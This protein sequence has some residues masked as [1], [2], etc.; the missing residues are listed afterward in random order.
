MQLIRKI[1]AQIGMDKAIAYSS[2]ARVIQGFTGIATIFFI[3]FFL[4]DV[5]QGFYFTFGSI[6]ALQIFFELGLTSI[7]TQYVAHEAA[8]LELK[9]NRFYQGEEKYKSRLASLIRFCLRWYA[10]LAVI[11]LLFLYVIGI[12]YFNKYSGNQ[13]ETVNWEWPWILICIGTSI[14]FFE[15]PLTSILTGLG[16]I[17]EMNK[18][19]FWQQLIIPTSTW[20][21][22][23]CG[24]KLYVI[25]IGYLLSTIVWFVYVFH[26]KLHVI[27]FNLLKEKISDRVEYLKEI[28]PYQWRIALSWISGYFVFQFFTP[29]L[30]ATEGAVVAGQ[31]G[32]TLQALN[33]IQGIALCWLNTKVPIY[34]KFIALKDYTQLDCLFNKTTKQTVLVSGCLLILFVMFIHLLQLTQISFNG[35]TVA[36]RFLNGWPLFMMATPVFFQQFVNSWATYLRCH[37]KEPL[38]TYSVTNAILCTFSILYIGRFFGLYGLT[39]SYCIIEIGMFPWVYWLYHSYKKK[40]H[41]KVCD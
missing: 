22:F 35:N 24:L 14:K 25:G 17:K 10:I 29:V 9:E 32:M 8:H 41:N 3:A 36:S 4:T 33:A 16:F 37:K 27:I 13:T 5:E 23:L 6:V 30:F 26:K 40:W 20:I 2:G 12:S 28:F 19:F 31:M 21:G 38:L 11:I 39:T 34:S 15:S 18:I 1:G 7:M